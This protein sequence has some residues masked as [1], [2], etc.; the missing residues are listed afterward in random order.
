M[1]EDVGY[2]YARH[3]LKKKEEGQFTNH[4]FVPT[5]VNTRNGWQKDG[6][7]TNSRIFA[8]DIICYPSAIRNFVL[9]S[10]NLCNLY[11]LHN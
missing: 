5:E 7:R 10:L 6:R 1:R 3:L 4:D 2:R 11:V 8:F 9:I